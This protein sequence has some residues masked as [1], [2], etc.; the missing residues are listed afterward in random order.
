MQKCSLLQHNTPDC[1]CPLGTCLLQRKWRMR[2]RARKLQRKRDS[3]ATRALPPRYEDVQAARQQVLATLL[4]L[5]QGGNLRWRPNASYA[6]LWKQAE[7]QQHML[8]TG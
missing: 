2:M 6:L 4:A 8:A 1:S 5:R 7:E 3:R